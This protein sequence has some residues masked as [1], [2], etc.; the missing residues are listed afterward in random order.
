MPLDSTAGSG[1]SVTA[2]EWTVALDQPVPALSGTLPALAARHASG[3]RGYAL[4]CRPDLPPRTQALAS[5][6]QPLPESLLAPQAMVPARL[7]GAARE[8]LLAVI[9]LPPGPPILTTHTR[10][11]PWSESE[12]VHDLL[13]PVAR[14]LAALEPAGIT[15]RGVRVENLFR[16]RDGG[17]VA[18]GDGFCLPPA[19]LQPPWCESLP[20]A[21]CVPEGRGAGQPADDIFAL[22]IAVISVAAGRVPWAAADPRDLHRLRL[23]KGS[24]NALVSEIR[25]PAGLAD[26]LRVMLADDPE[27][28]P[29]A[30]FVA[31]WPAASM[32]GRRGAVRPVRRA[33]RPLVV[34][35]EKAL[36]TRAAAWLLASS[37]SEGAR[38][39]RSGALDGFV[40]RGIG[41]PALA[42]RL[43]ET[44][45]TEQA[46]RPDTADDMAMCRAIAMLDPQAPLCWR[47]VAMMP[48]GIGTLLARAA[49]SPAEAPLTVADIAA[50]VHAEAPA[51]WALSGGDTSSAAMHARTGAQWRLL[52]RTR[53]PAGGLERLLYQLNPG[54]PCLSPMLRGVWA[55]TPASLLAALEAVAPGAE[56][57]GQGGT[58]PPDPAIA[59]YLAARQGPAAERALAAL[60]APAAAAAT[61]RVAVLARLQ[62]RHASD[63]RLPRLA[64]WL[65]SACEPVL[66]TW[67]SRLTREA[68]P[69]R[70]AE[71]AAAGDLSTV[72]GLLDDPAA[73]QADMAGARAAAAELAGIDAELAAIA[74]GAPLRRAQARAAGEQAA[75][76]VSVT[77]LL[78]IA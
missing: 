39:L 33:A 10:C 9:G 13:H 27:L 19:F 6:P 34:G 38:A 23:E 16:S 20:M 43:A 12:L 26:L 7:A 75:A 42:E 74:A 63:Q 8:S 49:C 3:R 72:H 14:V 77:C 40:R 51:R 36:D 29:G 32:Q 55:A 28:R 65:A 22:G 59:A 25:L 64:A 60:E 46:E 21:Q 71:A 70:L 62:A 4:A 52:L 45:R 76:G 56:A 50:L 73:R 11:R 68:L 58:L 47:G 57:A 17:P 1:P 66:A 53:G 15:H 54:L 30:E 61:A 31:A 41:D 48:D 67:H 5:L 24:F 2:G 69:A 44:V 37:W 35:T 78:G 18:L